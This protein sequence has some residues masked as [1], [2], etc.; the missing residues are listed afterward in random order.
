MEEDRRRHPR[1]AVNAFV[2]FY[3]QSVEKTMRRYRQG[4]VKNYSDGGL[5]VSTDNPLPQGTPITV[6]IPIE[7]ETAQI[8]ILQIRGVVRWVYHLSGRWGMGIE[9]FGF[10]DSEHGDF[11]DW[12]SN[13]EVE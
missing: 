8:K 1:I 5:F 11:T 12:M 13:L 3:E 9:F 7:S 2:R 10:T 6:E 4:V